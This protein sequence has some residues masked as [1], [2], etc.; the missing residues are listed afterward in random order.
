MAGCNSFEQWILHIHSSISNC[1]GSAYLL[2]AAAALT[3]GMTCSTMLYHIP[4]NMQSEILFHVEPVKLFG[5]SSVQNKGS[6]IIL[7]CFYAYLYST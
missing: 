3:T 2:P 5:T 1:F 6:R 7:L 4:G